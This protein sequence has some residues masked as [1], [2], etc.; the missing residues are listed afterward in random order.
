M[1][2][3]ASVVGL[4]LLALAIFF[5]AAVVGKDIRDRNRNDT[6]TVTGSA[7]QR[8]AS[9]YVIWDASV[10]VRGDTQPEAAKALRDWTGKVTA[11]LHGHG[12][13]DAE[14]IFQ[15][16]TVNVVSSKG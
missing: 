10:G 1:R 4:A 9:D 11:F 6:I 16:A 8:I 3:A 13:Q 15:P 7:K 14:I 5:G 12:V 2:E